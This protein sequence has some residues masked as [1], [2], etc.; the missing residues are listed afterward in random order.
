M[1]QSI[2]EFEVLQA[3]CKTAPGIESE[4]NGKRLAFQLRPYVLE[5][6]EQQFVPSPVF[7]KIE[8]S[9][10]ESLAYSVSGAL[11]SLGTKFPSLHDDISDSIT[12]FLAKCTHSI[13]NIVASR[14]SD[15][16]HLPPRE[17]VRVATIVVALLG[18]LDAA[19]A[20]ANF[21]KPRERLA[22]I[23]KMRSMLSDAFLVVV[24]TALSTILNSHA[25]EREIKD[26]KRYLRH[27]AAAG[28]PLGALLLQRSFM[29][30]IVA[31][32][33][34]AVAD[35]DVLRGSH[36]L[37][38][39]MSRG[40]KPNPTNL[41]MV[42]GDLQAYTSLIIDQVNYIQAGADF[43]LIS[44]PSSQKLAHGLK[45]SAMISYLN[46]AVLNDEIADPDKLVVWIQEIMDNDGPSMMEDPESASVVLRCLAVVCNLSQA[47]SPVATLMKYLVDSAPKGEMVNI[48]VHCLASI[49]KL[50]SKDAVFSA[51]YTLGDKLVPPSEGT[52]ISTQVNGDADNESEEPAEYAGRSSI[53]STA[54]LH[55]NGNE[56]SA[57]MYD[58]IVR[59]IC[60]IGTAC[61]DEQ[62][63][64][65]AQS[66]LLQKL[67]K[68]NTSVDAQIVIGAAELALAGG[69]QQF[70]KLLKD[71]ARMSHIG[72][73][74]N[75]EHLLHAVS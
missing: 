68:I 39:L 62:I 66:M 30:L 22:V 43:V 55:P 59:A 44:S 56:A 40:S 24:E 9:P 33:S 13:E 5:A 6:I 63:A 70:K 46:C 25:Q 65:L 11:L 69:Q 8:P 23:H 20:Q 74:E 18:F 54:S 19:S 36:I 48:A 16:D 41:S 3:L 57:T 53:T 51:V 28:R 50:S 75:K 14:A 67:N 72:V 45:A 17:A 47:S 21:W 27:Y 35:E 1:P 12:T 42:E 52:H 37:D 31:S 61:D 29:W 26:W 58:N 2:R 4:R 34:L 32:T 10:N 15:R 60:G 7:R 73:L 49:L 38:V 64:A 71:Y